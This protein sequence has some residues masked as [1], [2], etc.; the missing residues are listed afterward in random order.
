MRFGSDRLRWF[1]GFSASPFP[2]L[3]VHRDEIDEVLR[4]P[5]PAQDGAGAYTLMEFVRRVGEPV[6]A[7]VPIASASAVITWLEGAPTGSVLGDAD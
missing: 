4:S 6:Q 1:R 7:I 3:S 5:L 2:E